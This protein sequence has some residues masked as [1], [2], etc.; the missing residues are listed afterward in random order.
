MRYYFYHGE[1]NLQRLSNSGVLLSNSSPWWGSL[2]KKRLT[3][4]PFWP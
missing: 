3:T 1:G 4:M 2:G